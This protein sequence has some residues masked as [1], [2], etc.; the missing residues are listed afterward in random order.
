MFNGFF[1][2]LGTTVLYMARSVQIINIFFG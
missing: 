1:L 2:K